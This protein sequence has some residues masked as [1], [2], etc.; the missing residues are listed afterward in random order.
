MTE[1]FNENIILKARNITKL[2]P[3]TVALNRVDFNV[4]R[5]KVN[6]LVGENGAGKST[7]TKFLWC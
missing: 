5:G 6:A 1:D 2:Y 3:G 4:Y 7:L